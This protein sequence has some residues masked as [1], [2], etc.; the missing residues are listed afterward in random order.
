MTPKKNNTFLYLSL[1]T[2]FGAITRI[3][4]FWKDGLHIDEK[5]TFDLV[6]SNDLTS[7]IAFS[8]T[9]DCNPPLFY[10]I[11]WCF[12]H[13]LGATIFA[14]RLPSVIF[15]I[16][17]IPTIYHFGKELRSK[18]LGLFSSLAV[19]TL[20]P[21]WY[22]SQ[23]GRAYMLECLLFTIMCVYY[24]RLV[25]GESNTHNWFVVSAMAVLL[26]YTHLFS[27]IPIAFMF[28]YLMWQYGK[29]SLQWMFG[30]FVASSP[31]LLLFKAMMDWRMVTRGTQ[32][33]SEEWYGAPFNQIIIFAPLEF[34]GYSFVF[35]IPMIIY[36]TWMYRN[37]R[38]VVVIASAFVG[39]FIVL[40]AI[41]NTTPVFLRYLVLL[42]PPMLSIGL[43]PVADFADS[44]EH[45]MAQKWFVIGSFSTF[46][47]AIIAFAFWSGLYISKGNYY[48]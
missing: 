9:H 20:G 18:T 11:D 47:F 3:W 35:W 38:E 6:T 22:Y 16:L 27:I 36:A 41:C 19:A 45:T 40:L 17:L 14:E 23:F 24:I 5:Y 12:I 7:V 29:E 32:T 44:T 33:W 4:F 39:S 2:I 15:G 1:I 8:L 25:R 34:F 48:V 43:L 21:L 46:Y 28:I 10:V 30:T 31:L 42:V 26:A 37:M 13:L